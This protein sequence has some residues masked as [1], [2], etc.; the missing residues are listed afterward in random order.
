[1]TNRLLALAP[2]VVLSM[3]PLPCHGGGAGPKP[4]VEVVLLEVTQDSV[5]TVT[6]GLWEAFE[7][8]GNSPVILHIDSDGGGVVAGLELVRSIEEMK[9]AYPKKRL[10][11]VV[12]SRAVSMGFFI[13]QAVCDSRV[14]H[15]YSFLLAHQVAIQETGG[16]TS[17]LRGTVAEME[18]LDYMLAVRSTGPGRMHVTPEQFLERIAMGDWV[19]TADYAK[20]LGAVDTVIK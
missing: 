13:L 1:M 17:S 3:S 15:S 9:R 19:M 11:C 2:A 20:E 5:N 4:N 7:S 12:E 10:V 14:M 6:D 16:N 18:A 8:R